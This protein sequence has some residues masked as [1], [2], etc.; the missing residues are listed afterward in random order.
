MRAKSKK[1]LYMDNTFGH[2]DPLLQSLRQKAEEAGVLNMQ[3]SAHE[4]R[5]L[6]FLASILKAKKIVE[7]GSLYGYS[8]VYLSRALP[9]DG[10]IFTC[11]ISEK[12]HQITQKILKPHPEYNKIQW[13]TGDAR[14]TLKTLE[15][16]GPFDIIFIDADKNSY[17]AYLN[18]AE[19]NV[20]KGGL[21]IADNTFL[22]GS[23]YGEPLEAKSGHSPE[24]IEVM[25]S[26]NKR[27]SESD[28]WK[29]ALIPT[30]EGLTIAIKKQS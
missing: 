2:E 29:G 1:N 11:D 10:R 20:R 15:T 23:V 12:R 3:I 13:I 6:W 27:L 8:T 19:K 22:F 21:L 28:S 4:G 14:H 17:S 16:K 25:K 18:W 5:I 26:F 7:I 9:E 30:S 24:T